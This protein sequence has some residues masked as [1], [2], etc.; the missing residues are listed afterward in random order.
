MTRWLIAGSMLAFA[1]ACSVGGTDAT[2]PWR[3]PI[4]THLPSSGVS[5]RE[6]VYPLVGGDT[7]DRPAVV[8]PPGPTFKTTPPAPKPLV[9]PGDQYFESNSAA[10]TP[11]GLKGLQVTARQLFAARRGAH[12]RIVGNT[13]SRGSEA[14]NFTL[15]LARAQAVLAVFRGAGFDA[16]HLAAQGAGEGRPVAQDVKDGMFDPVAGAKNR[17]VV[18]YVG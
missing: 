10:L 15:S 12:L 17:R 1:A 18:I 9:V 6:P 4:A 7:D 16:A 13:D 14:A 2:Q 5:G 3:D 11:A 8:E